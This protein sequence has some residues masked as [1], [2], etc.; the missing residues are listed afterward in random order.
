MTGLPKAI[1]LYEP[2]TRMVQKGGRFTIEKTGA[3]PRPALR[4]PRRPDA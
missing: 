4:A 1:P 2:H 3:G